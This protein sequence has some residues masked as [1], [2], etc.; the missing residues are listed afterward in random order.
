MV[1]SIVCLFVLTVS[2][3][4]LKGEGMAH[5]KPFL[6]RAEIGGLSSLRLWREWVLSLGDVIS[7]VWQWMARRD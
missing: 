7:R 2:M 4:A 6:K 3:G 1:C 5:K